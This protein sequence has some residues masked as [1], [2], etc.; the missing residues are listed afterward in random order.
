M[1][2]HRIGHFIAVAILATTILLSPIKIFASS[3]AH[4]VSRWKA[5]NSETP[6]DQTAQ[7][8]KED[9]ALHA[10]ITSSVPAVLEHTGSEAFDA[11]LK[12]VQAVLRY[13]GPDKKYLS[14]AG[15]FHSICECIHR[16]G[17]FYCSLNTIQIILHSAFSNSFQMAQ[18]DF[19]AFLCRWLREMQ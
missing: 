5:P 14:D 2:P 15:L 3:N 11:H 10:Y 6:P 19:K 9:E 18:R 4:A 17:Y 12:G 13:W 7:W 16:C 1:I 8:R